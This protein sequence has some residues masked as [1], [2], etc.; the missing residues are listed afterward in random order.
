MKTFYQQC[1]LKQENITTVKWLPEKHCKIGH[2][3]SI[4]EDRK[5]SNAW[6]VISVSEES[7]TDK[8]P[9]WRKLIRGLRD[10]TGDSLPKMKRKK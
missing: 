5:W 3:I 6:T 8:P 2:R 1:Q 4:K 10:A 7:R 9:D